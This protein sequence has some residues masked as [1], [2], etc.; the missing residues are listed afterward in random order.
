MN[1]Q[2]LIASLQAQLANLMAQLVALKAKIIKESKPTYMPGTTTPILYLAA[3]ECLGSHVTLDNSVPIDVGCAEAV[4]YVLTRIGVWDGLKG[5]AGTAALYNWLL[6]NDYFQ[7]IDEPEP[8]AILVSQTGAG[9]GFVEGHTG[10]VGIFGVQFPGDFGVMSNNSNNGIFQEK[11][12]IKAWAQ[13]YK[14]AGGLPMNYFRYVGAATKLL[15][16][17]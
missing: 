1:T 15:P 5:I 13:H 3:K 16:V 17:T 9:N 12:S 2:Q 4:S 7:K 10:I 11:W 6:T 8:G 14:A